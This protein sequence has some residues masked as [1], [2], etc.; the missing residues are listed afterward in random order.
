MSYNGSLTYWMSNSAGDDWEDA[1][2][3]EVDAGLGYKVTDAVTYSAVAAFAQ[4]NFDE[5]AM[6]YDDAESAYRLYHKL[7]IKF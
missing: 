6:G 7:A 5:D 3:F 2:G 1:N 4:F